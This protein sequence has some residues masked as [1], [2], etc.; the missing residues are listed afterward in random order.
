MSSSSG[1]K[2]SRQN[3]LSSFAIAFQTLIAVRSIQFFAGP[4]LEPSNFGM[5]A[6]ELK[7]NTTKATG[8]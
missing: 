4:G 5:V 7:Q 6:P 3:I 8:Y 2:R 1:H